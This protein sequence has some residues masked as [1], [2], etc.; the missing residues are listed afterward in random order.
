[1]AAVRGSVLDPFSATAQTGW[2]P[3]IDQSAVSPGAMPGIARSTGPAASVQG[4]TSLV[5]LRNPL[6]WFALLAAA[7]F[8]LVGFSST[9]RVGKARGRV[10]VGKE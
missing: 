1:M 8:G 9:A 4:S 5:S 7:T 10:S 6:T 2:V 3:Q